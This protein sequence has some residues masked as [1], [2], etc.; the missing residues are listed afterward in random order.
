MRREDFT[1]DVNTHDSD[2][3]IPVLEVTF[4]GTPDDLL[5]RLLD[6][7]G[8]TPGSSE[9]DLTFRLNDPLDEP[10]ATGV[11][12]ITDRLTGE[13]VLEV[14]APVETVVSF[15][16]TARECDDRSDDDAEYRMVILA[17][18]EELARYEK[19]TLLVYGAD[20]DLLRKH[21]LI[22]SGVEI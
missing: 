21:S 7:D 19:R 1:L 15:V 5:Q 4:D 10:G 9:T 13:Y 16:R 8:E 2:S 18:G 20:G 3:G 6:R 17:G 11:L 14:D 22:P 12:A